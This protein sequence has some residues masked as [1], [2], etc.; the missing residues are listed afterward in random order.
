M[1]EIKMYENHSERKVDVL[2]VDKEKTKDNRILIGNDE[3]V[4][5]VKEYIKDVGKIKS[6]NVLATELLLTASPAFFKNITANDQEKWIDK[7]IK[8]LKNRYGS[9]F[10]YAS[11]HL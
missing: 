11:L 8:W 4:K 6:N 3:V 7:N 10:I 9:Q 2:N 1:I 5:T